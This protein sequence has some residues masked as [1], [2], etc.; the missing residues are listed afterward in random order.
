MIQHCPECDAKLSIRR[1]LTG[2]DV[3]CPKCH[4]VFTVAQ[5][6]ALARPRTKIRPT[7]THSIYAWFV[8]LPCGI[9]MLVLAIAILVPI[10]CLVYGCYEARKQAEL[11][12]LEEERERQ[13]QRELEEQRIRQAAEGKRRELDARRQLA[14]QEATN[15]AKRDKAQQEL[16][17]K[18][19][20]AEERIA[21]EQAQLAKERFAQ[22]AAEKAR[23]EEAAE[24]ERLKKEHGRMIER[25]HDEILA[26]MRQ[27]LPVIKNL[28]NLLWYDPVHGALAADSSKQ[29][30]L[31]RL[32]GRITKV[33]SDFKTTT[34]TLNY[35]F[36]VQNLSILAWEKSY[37]DYGTLKKLKPLE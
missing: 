33:G 35:Y 4:Q 24:A 30:K 29:G 28:K 25:D 26:Y 14:L 3:T 9:L 12:A 17:L 36:L 22:E 16:E 34:E 27:N 7:G 11:L 21:A 18:R 20:A 32:Q 19:V 15:R 10:G 5:T 2:R 23:R 31:Y 13:Y 6:V 8:G 1:A 37:G